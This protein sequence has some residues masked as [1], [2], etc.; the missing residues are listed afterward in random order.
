MKEI[1][2][3]NPYDFKFQQS[4]VPEIEA[5]EALV[6]VAFCAIC[7]TDI[8]V[9][10]GN[11]KKNISYP[12]V[13][14]HEIS[15]TIWKTGD[16]VDA[17]RVGDRVAVSPII[18]CGR[19]R[20]CLAGKENLCLDRLAIGYQFPGGF[21]EYLR[22]PEAAI[23]GGSL[24][25]ISDRLSLEE[26]ALIE[27]V[28]CCINGIKKADIEINDNVLIV[29]AG[30]IGQMHL[31]LCRLYGANFVAVSDPIEARR[32]KARGFGASVAIDPSSESVA[33]AASRRGIDGFDKIIFACPATSAVNDILGLCA[34]GGTVLLFSGFS[35]T[36]LCNLQ[37]N[38]IHYNE[39]A[40][41]GST[42]YRRQDYLAALSLLENGKIDVKSLISDVF[43]I[44]EFDAAYARHKSGQGFKVLIKP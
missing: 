17:Y 3:S 15:G 20:N 25:K 42:G 10:E 40:V 32:E 23:K 26:A 37:L 9:L 44:E 1:L 4:F 29:G 16:A 18:P 19:C 7:A 39:L 33:E 36:G 11:K 2:L 21:A 6:K 34:K 8:R 31:Q 30:A 41:I 38:T 27:P 12:C 5:S 28:A 35:G 13:I 14:G 43:P 22:I 24:V